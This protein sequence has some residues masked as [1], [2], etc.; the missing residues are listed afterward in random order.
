[1]LT[2]PALYAQKVIS[3]N[4]CHPTMV[5]FFKPASTPEGEKEDGYNEALSDFQLYSDAVQQPLKEKG[6][7]TKVVYAAG[8]RTECGKHVS[9]FVAHKT[10]V[11]YY[12]IA[13][14]KSPRIQYGVKTKGD[15]LKIAD[16]YF[17][18]R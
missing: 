3:I 1:M 8:F 18:H 14:G 15:L 7:N 13:P 10:T 11:G 17:G 5:A 2:A 4:V 6:I 12:F 9:T 16:E